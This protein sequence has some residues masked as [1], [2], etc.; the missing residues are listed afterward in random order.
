M[1]GERT[2]GKEM[3]SFP[4]GAFPAQEGQRCILRGSDN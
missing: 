1:P 3:C 4:K 2:V